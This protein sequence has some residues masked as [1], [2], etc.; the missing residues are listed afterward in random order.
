MIGRQPPVAVVDTV[1]DRRGT[2]QIAEAYLQHLY[3]KQGQQLAAKHYFRP[4]DAAV[5]A[6]NVERFPELNLFTIGE[7]FGDWD[8]AYEKHFA[9]SAMFD[10]IYRGGRK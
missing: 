3:S 7:V 5:L 4:R 8:R 10:R 9:D 1:V 6:A 2:R